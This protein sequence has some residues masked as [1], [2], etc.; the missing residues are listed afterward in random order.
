MKLRYL[1]LFLIGGMLVTSIPAFAAEHFPQTSA[2]AAVVAQS[3]S[4][5]E[6]QAAFDN[7]LAA[8]ASHKAENV[9]KLYAKDAV[10]LPT[11]SP[12]VHNTP[13]LRLAYFNVFTAKPDIKGTV[14]E[15]HI[16]VFGNTAVNSGLYTFTFTK[17]GE[18]QT[19][20]ARYSF[21]YRK[22]SKGWLIVDHHS[23]KLPTE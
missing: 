14:D 3:D 2:P 15:S 16:R 7:W 5:A 4:K 17:D 23:S 21:V 10:L 22:T 20:P 19:V 13:E 9:A 11:L 18:T 8:V 12:K 1:R 6:V